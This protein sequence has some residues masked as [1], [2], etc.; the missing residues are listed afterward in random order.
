MLPPDYREGRS[1]NLHPPR[2]NADFKWSSPRL[3]RGRRDGRY[4]FSQG[5]LAGARGNGRDA[6]TAAAPDDFSPT[7][8]FDARGCGQM[9]AVSFAV[10]LGSHEQPR[11]EDALN[12]QD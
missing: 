2:P 10:V 6:P 4:R 1:Q 3:R 8:K 12:D 5:T 11:P 7:G 9:A